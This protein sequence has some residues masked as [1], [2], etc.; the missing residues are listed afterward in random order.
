MNQDNSKKSKQSILS[1][2]NNIWIILG[3]ICTIGFLLRIIWIPHES[4]LTGDSTGYFG[5]QL[6]LQLLVVSPHQNVDGDA[7]FQTRDG[8]PFFQYFSQFFHLITI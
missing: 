3:V 7:H 4:P 6:T 8:H 2:F 1:Y 5:M